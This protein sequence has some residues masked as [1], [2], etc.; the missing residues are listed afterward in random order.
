[1]DTKQAIRTIHRFGYVQASVKWPKKELVA[2][3]VYIEMNAP[4]SEPPSERF[5]VI[6]LEAPDDSRHGD[7]VYVVLDTDWLG[8]PKLTYA[9]HLTEEAADDH[10]VE[11]NEWAVAEA[12]V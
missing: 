11:L 1:M 3:L 8:K 7:P 12:K 9:T 4:P 5:V 10:A 2:H 6:E